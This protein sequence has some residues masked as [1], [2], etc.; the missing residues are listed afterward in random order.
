MKGQRMTTGAAWK[1]YFVEFNR[2]YADT[3]R[4][5]RRLE[6]RGFSVE[7]IPHKTTL[8]IER[9]PDMT[10]EQFRNAIRSVLDPRL[11]AVIVFSTT[12]GNVFLC[13][14]RGNM[15][16]IMQQIHEAA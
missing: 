11:G 2:A 10:W 4:V 16:G 12:T 6:R 14:N 3:R 15:P 7:I 8:R 1:V 9:P 13:S 5:A